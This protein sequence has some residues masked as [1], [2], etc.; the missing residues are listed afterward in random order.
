MPKIIHIEMVY[1]ECMCM[2]LVEVCMLLYTVVLDLGAKCTFF[3]G[4]GNNYSHSPKL[5]VL[6]VHNASG[7]GSCVHSFTHCLCSLTYIIVHTHSIYTTSMNC[8]LILYTLA[9]FSYVYTQRYTTWNILLASCAKE[10]HCSSR[11][12]FD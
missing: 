4:S 6:N 7:P 8:V 5:Y 11:R 2:I 3:L 1:P 12:S 10:Q 9:L